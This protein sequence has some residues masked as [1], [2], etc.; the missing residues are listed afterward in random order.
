[1]SLYPSHA[2][3]CWLVALFWEALASLPPRQSEATLMG[4]CL[5]PSRLA[6]PA[7]HAQLMDATGPG[8]FPQPDDPLCKCWHPLAPAS[9]ER[10]EFWHPPPPATVAWGSEPFGGLGYHQGRG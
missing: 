7:L 2:A 10:G 3:S 8:A 6:F 9:Q 4:C 1:M 5:T